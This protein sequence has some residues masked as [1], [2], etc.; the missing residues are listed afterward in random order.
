M[1][2]RYVDSQMELARELGISLSAL[3]DWGHRGAPTR[4]KDKVK[5]RYNV[6]AVR[7]WATEHGYLEGNRPVTR[8]RKPDPDGPSKATKELREAQADEK[9]YKAR[10]AEL[11]ARRLEGEL[12]P[13]SEVEAHDLRRHEYMLSVLEQW[14]RGL[15]PELA[16]KTAL[17]INRIMVKRVHDVMKEF[18]G[19]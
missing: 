10:I 8:G 7:R 12:I 13:V 17:E 19:R 6:A 16:G 15:G 11:N 18:S 1:A 2:K 5:G 4:A 9:R 3:Y 14:A